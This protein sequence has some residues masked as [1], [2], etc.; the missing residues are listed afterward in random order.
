[1]ISREYAL[2]LF[3]YD[4]LTGVLRWR[5]QKG[6]AARGSIAGT[7]DGKGYLHVCV[8]YELIRVHVI[9][10]LIVHGFVPEEVDHR[11]RMKTDNRECNLRPATR[12]QMGNT[13]LQK[14]NTSGFKGVSLSSRSGMWHA[15]I[16]VSGKQTY[17]GRFNTPEEAAFCYDKAA[18][19]HFGEFAWLN[20]VG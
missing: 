19:E 6:A 14:N 3:T 5:V 8:D 2:E 18:R 17:L 9:A 7:V 4:S 16:K 20:Y 12:L 15:Q 11:N 10:F 13:G 1:M